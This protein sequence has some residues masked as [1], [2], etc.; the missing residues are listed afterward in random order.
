MRESTVL[1]AEVIVTAHASL[2]RHVFYNREMR[3]AHHTRI[4]DFA[5]LQP[6]ANLAAL[7]EVGEAA[8]IGIGAIV[9]ERARLEE[10]ATVAAGAV[11]LRDVAPRT[12]VARNPAV[13]KKEDVEAR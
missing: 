4:E 13:V 2:E 1:S 8:Y 11:V 12:I 9:T 7:I 5:T 10:E 3:I 6:D